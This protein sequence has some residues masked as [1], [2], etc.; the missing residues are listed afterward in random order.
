M[1]E[2][3]ILSLIFS[4]FL[5]RCSES[6]TKNNDDKKYLI[7]K[8][9]LIEQHHSEFLLNKHR[10]TLFT[11]GLEKYYNDFEMDDY[12]QYL[13][14]FESDFFSQNQSLRICHSNIRAINSLESN[15]SE[16]INFNRDIFLD[17][18]D[19]NDLLRKQILKIKFKNAQNRTSRLY[20]KEHYI[21]NLK[22]SD[23][24]SKKEFD[25]TFKEANLIFKSLDNYEI[26]SDSIYHS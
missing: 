14:D 11:D 12:S 1:K 20:D 8:E 25:L 10:L 3:T 7:L 5:F 19:F 15:K 23:A 24:I 9:T 22:P 13:S 4:I 18:L 6:K 21:E 16:L 17:F 2:L 26:I